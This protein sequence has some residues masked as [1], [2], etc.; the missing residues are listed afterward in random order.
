[1]VERDF[2]EYI[3]KALG[4]TDV[5]RKMRL[6]TMHAWRHWYISYILPK[7]NAE[8]AQKLARHKNAAMTEHYTHLTVEERQRAAI[9]AGELYS[10]LDG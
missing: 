6:L 10:E 2:A 3:C 5:T 1:M 7:T 4:M 9:A 8:L